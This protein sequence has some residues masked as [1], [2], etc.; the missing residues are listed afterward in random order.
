MSQRFTPEQCREYVSRHRIKELFEDLTASLLYKQPEDVQSFL[1]SELE[2]RIERD[3][4]TLPNF[5]PKEI[6]NV[7]YLF[8]LTGQKF[9]SQERCKEALKSVAHSAEYR[10]LIQDNDEIPDKVDLETFKMLAQNCL[11]AGLERSE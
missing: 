3:C 6:E 10:D 9:I 11:R 5:T 8:N 2:L 4:I 7:F 1:I